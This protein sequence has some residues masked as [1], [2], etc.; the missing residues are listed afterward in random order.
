VRPASFPLFPFF[1]SAFA[2]AGAG[3][4]AASFL[5]GID[6]GRP[7]IGITILVVIFGA[8]TF[9]SLYWLRRRGAI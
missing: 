5:V 7:W 2:L 6:P 8:I 9:A 3:R 4:V 1:L